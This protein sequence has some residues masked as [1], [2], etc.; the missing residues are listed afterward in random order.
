[1]DTLVF[2]DGR[3]EQEVAG[4]AGL[5][6]L[7]GAALFSDDVL[8]VT[9]TGEDLPQTFGPWL[10]RNGLSRDGL[11]FADPH[12][13]RNLL[14]Y[15]DERTRTETPI[16]GDEHFRRAEPNAA[17]LERAIVGARS[18]YIFRNDDPAFWDRA[19]ALHRQCPFVLLWEIALDACSPAQ[20]PA[21]EQLVA[22]VDALSLNL[23]ETRLIFSRAD[24]TELVRLLAAW[25]AKHIFLRVGGRGSYVIEQGAARFIP[26]L[27]VEPVDV[28][29]AGN[30]YS[31][32]ALV[33]LAQGLDG[34]QAAAMGAVAA[35][36][37]IRQ[38][39]LPEPRDPVVRDD[40]RATLGALLA[41][42]QGGVIA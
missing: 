19:L 16:Y 28:T 39:G 8:L 18:A 40:A 4:G 17:D 13:P 5:H 6:A 31:G 36:M 37:A 15:I 11:R 22:Q 23:E 12:T 35:G 9:G 20:R 21:I 32:A 27:G 30:A 24:E 33:G 25:P 41:Q 2:A 42:I 3:A 14:H 26:S 10:D 1:M 38:L 7:A 34:A 29:G